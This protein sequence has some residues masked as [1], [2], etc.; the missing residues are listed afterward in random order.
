[1]MLIRS[2]T[3]GNMIIYLFVVILFV[4]FYYCNY[5]LGTVKLNDDDT[6]VTNDK[7]ATEFKVLAGARRNIP[8]LSVER[9]RPRPPGIRHT[10]VLVRTSN[11][12]MH[13]RRTSFSLYRYR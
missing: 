3:T 8:R 12:A 5:V 6:T 1:M 2:T 9:V 11:N 7:N 10:T 13:D 4:G